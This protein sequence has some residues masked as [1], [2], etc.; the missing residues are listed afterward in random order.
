[1]VLDNNNNKNNNN[2]ISTRII[3]S[4]RWIEFEI[5]SAKRILDFITVFDFLARKL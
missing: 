2:S 3:H 5:V 4:L 1:M